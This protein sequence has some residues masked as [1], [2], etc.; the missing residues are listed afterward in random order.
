[1][2]RGRKT[3]SQ[4][5]SGEEAKL[6]EPKSKPLRRQLGES[7]GELQDKI[8]EPLQNYVKVIDDGMGKLL[9]GYSDSVMKFYET[10]TPIFS[11]LNVRVTRPFDPIVT[12]LEARR[13]IQK[14]ILSLK[15][16]GQLRLNLTCQDGHTILVAQ[17]HEEGPPLA[18]KWKISD[19]DLEQLLHGVVESIPCPVCGKPATLSLNWGNPYF[20]GLYEGIKYTIEFLDNT[21]KAKVKEHP[22]WPWLETINGIGELKAARIIAQ[23]EYSEARHGLPLSAHSLM[24]MAGLN[25]VFVCYNCGLVSIAPALSKGTALCPKCSKAMTGYAPTKINLEVIKQKLG[26]LKKRVLFH[27]KK[28]GIVELSVGDALRKAGGRPEFNA[29]WWFVIQSFLPTSKTRSVYTAVTLKAMFDLFEE[30]KRSKTVEALKRSKRRS[31]GRAWSGVGTLLGLSWRPVARV[32]LVHS[33][34]MHNFA[35]KRKIIDP[36]PSL[37]KYLKAENKM[38]KLIPPLTDANL[39]NIPPLLESFAREYGKTFGIDVYKAWEYWQD[40]RNHIDEDLIKL[41]EYIDNALRG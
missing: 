26:G 27:S 16:R 25:T 2:T 14:F 6:Q 36:A 13:D 4:E 20:A 7:L 40:K 32:L 11:N 5:S 34:L 30:K 1:M 17:P 31:R 9:E 29:D 10:P 41:R 37:T 35:K 18:R 12:A 8:T 33:V 3:K 38:D 28:T 15:N 22:I 24:H 19:D 39:D 23:L 21:L